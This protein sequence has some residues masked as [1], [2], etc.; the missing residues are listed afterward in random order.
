MGRNSK[1]SKH[2]TV[3]RPQDVAVD[4]YTGGGV[5]SLSH[6]TAWFSNKAEGF[7]RGTF[8][9]PTPV[10]VPQKLEEAAREKGP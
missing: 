5:S 7:C 2:A 4:L 8:L 9:V 10:K 3:W 1:D 6:V